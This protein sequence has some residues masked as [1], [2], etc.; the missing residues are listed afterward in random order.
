MSNLR[1]I[2]RHNQGTSRIDNLKDS[3]FFKIYD[4]LFGVVSAELDT[5]RAVKS[6]LSRK[7]TV[8]ATEARLSSCSATLRVAIDVGIRN[9]RT[10]S[11]KAL[12][13]H[14][15]SNF[16]SSDGTL[17]TSLAGDYAKNLSVLLSYESHVEHLPKELWKTVMEFCLEKIR[18]SCRSDN[19][20]GNSILSS[21]SSRSHFAPSQPSMNKDMLPRQAVDDLVDVLRS[22]TSVSFAPLL[23]Q[24]PHILTA[25]TQ[26]VNT[27]P[28]MSKPQVDALVVI[29]STLLQV[30]TEDIKLTKKF[31][32]DALSFTKALWNTKLAALKDETLSMLVLLH[33]YIEVLS[34]ENEEELFFIEMS[35][36]VDAI[37]GEYTKR[38][39]KDQL[40]LNQLTLRLAL[41]QPSDSLRCQVF[42]LR[43]G[44]TTHENALSSEHSWTLLKLLSLLS[45][46]SHS[47]DPRNVKSS[48]SPDSGP[49]KRQRIT[50]WSDELI[51]MLSDFSIATKLTALQLICFVAQSVTIEEEALSNLI[52]KLAILITDDNGS[53]ASWAHLALSR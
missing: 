21:R 30:R 38:G 15:L 46:W 11:V 49:Q 2:L 39:V 34:Q 7:T 47:H 20:L 41:K 19:G 32:R 5:L 50:Q 44:Q 36:L 27:S 42:A 14:L 48:A 16:D 24:G 22:L 33:P 8:S 1:Q 43:D 31:T 17:N 52:E 53:I 6:G 37:K 4:S 28:H 23:E 29:N 3:G 12:I 35:N 10:K 9:I 45:V 13:D 40:Q 18:S 51:R 25:M 26:F